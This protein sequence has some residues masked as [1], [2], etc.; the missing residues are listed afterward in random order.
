VPR[1]V[2]FLLLVLVALPG[3]ARAAD[4]P[5][6]Y[7]VDVTGIHHVDWAYEDAGAGA[8][9][10]NWSRGSGSQTIGFSH[11]RPD[12]YTLTALPKAMRKYLPK[13]AP[14]KLWV[15]ARL[16]MAKVALQREVEGWTDHLAPGRC[17]PCEQEGGCDGPAPDPIPPPAPP[18]DCPRRS[19]KSP[20][21][22]NFYPDGKIP[23][24][25]D[26]LVAPLED[27]HPAF[28]VEPGLKV[29]DGYARCY[30]DLHR[31]KLQTGDPFRVSLQPVSRILGLRAG[32]SVTLKAS[33]QH[34]TVTPPGGGKATQAIRCPAALAGPGLRDCAVTDV[35]VVVR[36]LR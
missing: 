19:Q 11:T 13:E 7:S 3:G 2:V 5:K 10:G 26:G 24:D 21:A 31:L 17:T 23:V 32:G 36:R 12:R 27:R 33:A 8:E 18:T 20:I 15:P 1:L 6:R 9:C 14:A 22:V 4:Q 30:P 28:A 34:Y 29:G 25:D 35:T 16:G